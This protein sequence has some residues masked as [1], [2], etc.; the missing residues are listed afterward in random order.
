MQH[1][2][3]FEEQVALTPKDMRQ[4]IESIDAV[5]LDKLSTNMEGRCSKNG[6]VLSGTV[7]ILSRSMGA[8]EKGRFTGNILFHVQAEATVLNP[9]DGTILEGEVIRKNKMGMYVSYMDA[10]RVIIPRDLYIGDEGYDAV[11]IG[12]RIQVEIKKSRFQVNDPYILSIGYF[13]GYAAKDQ[14]NTAMAAVAAEEAEEAGEEAEEAGEAE[15][16]EEAEE[17]GEAKEEAE[18]EAGEAEEEA[19]E[20]AESDAPN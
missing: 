12:E 15:E 9:S 16:A 14:R 19:E 18:E 1:T 5:L 20:A 2:A 4:D 3:I 6:Y 7:K 17:A 13:K 10:I 11:Q 8:M